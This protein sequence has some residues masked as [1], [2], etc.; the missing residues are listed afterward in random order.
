MEQRERER[1][2]ERILGMLCIMLCGLSK[3][4]SL[5]VTTA[6]LALR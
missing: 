2:R 4:S 3:L 1:E 5:P 6:P